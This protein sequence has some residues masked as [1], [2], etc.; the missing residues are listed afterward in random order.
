MKHWLAVLGL[1]IFSMN[2]AAAAE[3]AVIDAA[4]STTP[5]CSTYVPK[6]NNYSMQMSAGQS[7]TITKIF[8][9]L[10]STAASDQIYIRSIDANGSAGTL[11]ATFAYSSEVNA[12]S[13]YESVFTGTLNVSMCL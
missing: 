9:R 13:Y 5:T 8:I 11:L 1:L 4:T 6:A 10:S 12:G 3:T 7:T 2:S